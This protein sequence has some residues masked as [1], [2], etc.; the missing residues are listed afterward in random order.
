MKLVLFTAKQEFIYHSYI[1][2]Q[3]FNENEIKSE[4]AKQESKI[5]LFAPTV[6][7]LFDYSEIQVQVQTSVHFNSFNI[8]FINLDHNKDFAMS[9]SGSAK[10]CC[11]KVFNTFKIGLLATN[12]IST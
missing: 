4:P 11:L 3:F 8:P 10:I 2:K 5:G 6:F 7:A 12:R 9:I 1:Y